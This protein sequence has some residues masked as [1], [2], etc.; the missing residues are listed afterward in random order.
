VI[1][2][3]A[4]ILP[5]F[6]SLSLPSRAWGMAALAVI[7]GITLINLAVVLAVWLPY[8]ADYAAI[9]AS[10]HKIDRGSRVLIGSTG[11]AGD[12]PFA[13]LTSYPMFY[14]PTLAVHYANA[15]VPNL[16]TEAG[17]QPVRAR[18]AVRRLAIPY[19][20]PVPSGLLAAIAT[21]RPPA[22]A[23]PFVRTWYQD[24]DYLYLLGPHAPNPLP[25]LLDE[26]DASERF[27]LYKIRRRS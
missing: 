13:D 15:F 22:D 24:F 3:A 10:F 6:C 16:F 25:D 23:P 7:S 14:A 18:E 2:A 12:P 8:R 19:G 26:L 4:L 20:G 17:K 11:D 5:A 1:A 27:V 9:V 21:G